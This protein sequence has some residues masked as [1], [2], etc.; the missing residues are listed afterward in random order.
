MVVTKA[1]DCTNFV[2]SGDLIT[3]W[4]GNNTIVLTLYVYKNC[5][6]AAIE[7]T[8]DDDVYDEDEEGMVITPALLNQSTS[9]IV[10]DIYYLNL[11][12]DGSTTVYEEYCLFINCA[13]RC[14][15]VNYL[16]DNLYSNI[17]QLYNTLIDG[18]TCSDDNCSKFCTIY[19][20]IVALLAESNTPD[21]G[22]CP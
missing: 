1:S 6:S 18:E 10:D 4:V 2:I 20:H 5:S 8:L 14:Q 9:A 17:G 11:R 12:S 22:N 13:T 3:A 21:C 19:N 7:I 16:G 15:I